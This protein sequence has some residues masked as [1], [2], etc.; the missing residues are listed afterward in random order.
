MTMTRELARASGC[1]KALGDIVQFLDH[2][3]RPVKEADRRPG[4]FPYYGAN[5]QQGTIDE[6]LFDEPLILVAED[7]GHFDNPGR[8]IAYR[9]DGKTWVNNHAHVLRPLPELVDIGYLCRVLENYD[10]RPFIS[11]TTRGKLTKAQ[12]ERIEIPLP[13]LPEQRRIA[14][15]LDKADA[16]RRKRQRAIDLLDSLTQSIFLEMFGEGSERL[17]PFGSTVPLSELADIG[18]GITKGRKVNGATLH[19]VP[20]LAVA[21]V[22]DRRLDMTVVKTIEATDAEIDRYRLARGDLLLTEGGDPD[23]LGRGTLWRDELPLA[24]HQNHIFRVRVRSDRLLPLFL[25]WLVGSRYGKAYFLSVAKQ[26]TGIASINKTQLSA[27]PVILPPLNDQKAFV[28][29][30]ERIRDRAT[31]LNEARLAACSLFSS[32]QHCAFSGQL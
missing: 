30:A 31:Q 20:Y 18:S 25:N 13:P 6:Y 15:S 32:L 28:E 21:N 4:P 8:G 9:I 12:A 2:R 22:Q 3:R 14:A 1:A 7:G 29:V 11:G 23:K 5:G 24:I 27:F 17:V 26:T 16:L 19:E 10:I